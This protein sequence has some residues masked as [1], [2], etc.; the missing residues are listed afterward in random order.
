MLSYF[1][2]L[3]I[4]AKY[5][6]H[7]TEYL[8]F[9]IVPLRGYSGLEFRKNRFFVCAYFQSLDLQEHNINQLEVV[10]RYFVE[11]FPCLEFNSAQFVSSNVDVRTLCTVKK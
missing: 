3:N 10:V 9:H 4:T 8:F 11:I 5:I 2:I 7:A 1:N 6:D